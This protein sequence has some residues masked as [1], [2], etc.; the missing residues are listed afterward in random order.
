MRPF[1]SD[2][3]LFVYDKK[4]WHN[5]CMRDYCLSDPLSVQEVENG[6]VLPLRARKDVKTLNNAFEGG[7]CDKDGNFVAGI[8]R[9]LKNPSTNLSCSRTY[10]PPQHVP[11]RHETV[12]FGG[13]L[14]AHFGHLITDSLTRLWWLAGHPDT[15]YKFCFLDTPSLAGGFKLYNVLEAA[16]ITRDRMEIITEPTQFD[17]IIVPQE[18]LYLHTN[19]RDGVGEIYQYISSRVTAGTHK[20]IYLSTAMLGESHTSINE[21]YYENFFRRRRY[22]IV[23]PEQLPFT[24]QVSLMAGAEEVV[25]TGGTLVHLCSF[26]KPGTRIIVLNRCRE[27]VNMVP[28]LQGCDLD[29]YV[30]DAHYSFLPGFLTGAR[31]YLLGPTIYWKQYLDTMG[32]IYEPEEL[33]MDLYVKPYFYE[34]VT[35]WGELN[36]APQRYHYIRNQSVVDLVDDINCILLQTQINRRALPDRDS[37]VALRRENETLKGQLESL[38]SIFKSALMEQAKEHPLALEEAVKKVG[39]DSIVIVD[40]TQAK[41]V[42]RG[43]ELVEKKLCRTEYS[44][45]WRLEDLLRKISNWFRE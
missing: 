10:R 3:Q 28:L 20:K 1:D 39:V 11:V 29:Y 15:S 16:G 25:C 38:Q 9:N 6:I 8:T 35:K 13:I 41:Q 34:Y 40:D 19:Y 4:A 12:I 33:S 26:C 42:E 36:A 22:E 44:L 23:Y 21:S 37:V 2:K 18:A 7:V 14:Y 32:I 24:E 30:I 5:I 31:V 17:K 45:P 43:A 27:K